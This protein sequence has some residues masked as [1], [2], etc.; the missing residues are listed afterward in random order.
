MSR[1]DAFLNRLADTDFGWWPF[2]RLRPARHERMGT[3]C[4]LRMSLHYG[5]LMGA[6]IYAWYVFVGFLPLSPIWP[7]ACVG[8]SVA[9]FFIV[10]RS[11]FAIAWNRRAARLAGQAGALRASE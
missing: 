8:A 10:V 11:T 4:L 1:L 3:R 5:A 2:L 7:I 6:V 9:F